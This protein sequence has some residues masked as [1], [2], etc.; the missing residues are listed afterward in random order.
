METKES[1]GL[2]KAILEG[3]KKTCDISEHE[4]GDY[5]DECV[6]EVAAHHAMGNIEHGGVDDLDYWESKTDGFES[7]LAVGAKLG[8]G[9]KV[10]TAYL[11]D[12]DDNVCVSHLFWFVGKNGPQL[13]RELKAETKKW[14]AGLRKEKGLLPFDA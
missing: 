13:I 12:D 8:E 4:V 14:L 1:K 11:G 7:G 2:R 9:D 5:F 10:W 3:I 6:A